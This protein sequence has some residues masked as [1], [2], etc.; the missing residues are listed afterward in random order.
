MGIDNA[1][2][3]LPTYEIDKIIQ[4]GNY[5]STITNSVSS[6]AI[7]YTTGINA[8]GFVIG[9]FSYDDGAT[10]RDMSDTS[11]ASGFTIY[12]SVIVSALMDSSGVIEFSINQ[13]ALVGAGATFELMI[14]FAVLAK[15][16]QADLDFVFIGGDTLYSSKYSYMKIAK[17]GSFTVPA[18][19]GS[20]Y[21]TTIPHNLGYVP[22]FNVFLE[23]SGNIQRQYQFNI[24][25]NEG[26][27]ADETNLYIY[28]SNFAGDV[29]YYYRIYYEAE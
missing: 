3:A 15:Q 6:K 19:S 14:R 1:A 22:F 12:P 20:G 17:Q 8:S 28:S 18:S 16:D 26:S 4:T 13:R 10:W 23:R 21:V 11:T 29:P 27:Y 9:V 24:P 5:S 2:L 25:T 7:D